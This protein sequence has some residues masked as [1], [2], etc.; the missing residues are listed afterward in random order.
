MGPPWP[1]AMLDQANF[2]VND[3]IDKLYRVNDFDHYCGFRIDSQRP[4]IG[5]R[6]G[7]W[8]LDSSCVL[9]VV[10][11]WWLGGGNVDVPKWHCTS[12]VASCRNGFC[13]DKFGKRWIELQAHMQKFKIRAQG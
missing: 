4:K 9:M 11:K 2:Y 1:T 13:T 8:I 12:V 7:Q 10:A 6:I 5:P 3:K